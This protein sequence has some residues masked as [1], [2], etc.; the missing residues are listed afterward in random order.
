MRRFGWLAAAVLLMG[1]G[2][3]AETY[4]VYPNSVVTIQAAIDAATHGDVIELA[5]GVFRGP[6]NYN[7]EYQGKQITVRS[8]SG[9]AA[10]CIIDCA[11]VS[12]PHGDYHRIGFI[13]DSFEGPGAILQNVTI[14]NGRALDT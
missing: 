4:L 13:F 11:P 7:I 3:G 14:A 12:P 10:N 9:N 2:A 6:G 5:D 8:Q 1:A